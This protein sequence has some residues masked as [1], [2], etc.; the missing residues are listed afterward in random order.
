MTANSASER[1]AAGDVMVKSPDD[2]AS[3]AK[4]P[5]LAEYLAARRSRA[6]LCG[7]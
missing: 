1:M 4:P 6:S 3:L 5:E 2:R 7:A